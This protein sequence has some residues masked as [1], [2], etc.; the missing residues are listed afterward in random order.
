[1]HL[2]IFV[3]SP[4]DVGDERGLAL[5]VL[6]KLPYAGG[7]CGKVAIEVVA[8]DKP[9]AGTPMLA[10]MTPQA[11]IAQG[12]PKP[13]ACDIVVVIFWSRMGT[14]LPAEYKKADGTPYVSGTEW[15]YLDALNAAQRGGMPQILVY[16]RTED[17]K[18]GMSDPQRGEK[19]SQWEKVQRFFASF[20]NPDGSI[21]GGVN[22]YETPDDFRE[23]LKDHLEKIIHGLVDTRVT[24]ATKTVT[25]QHQASTPLALW[26]GSPFPG[27]RTFTPDDAPIFFGREREA[28]ELVRRFADHDMRFVVVAGASGSGKSS[29]AA[30]GLLPRLRANAIE[31]SKDWLLP[32]SQPGGSERKVWTG[33]RFTPGEF[34]D[35]PFQALAAKLAPLMPGTELAPRRVAEDL[36]TSSNHLQQLIDRALT[37]KPSWAEA[38]L[39]ID[40]F[41]ELFTVMADQY[42]KPFVDM[43]VAAVQAPRLRIVATL[44]AD[45]YHRCIEAQPQLADILRQRGASF[46]LAPPG[47]FALSEMITGPAGRAGLDFDDGLADQILK[48]AGTSSG[49]L[50]LLA[51]AL[52]ELYEARSADARLTRAAYEAFGGVQRAI[53][54]RAEATFQNLPAKA[55]ALL[56][57]VFRELVDV[58]EGG[59]ATRRRA[60]RQHFESSADAEQLIDAFTEAR[61]L[62]M[63]RSPGGQVFV[64][65][66]HEALLRE[67][68]RLKDWIAERTD[69]L[70]LWRQAQSAAAEWLRAGR[71]AI[72]LW[73]H[74]R[75]VSLHDTLQRLALARDNLPEPVKGFV[76]PEAERLL[77]EL[78]R[79]ATTHYR[80]AE[81][82]DRLDRIGDP[83]PGVG[84]RPDGVPDIL[85]CKIPG[86]TLTLQDVKGS[87]SVEPFFMAKYPV[88]YRQ[89]RAFLEDPKGYHSKTWWKGLT[90]ETQ[91]GEQYRPTGNCPAD[92]VS[93]HS[94]IA[95]CRWLS[96]H[97]R[98][99]VRLPTE[100]EWQQAA[101][102][103]RAYLEYPWG[104]EG[105]EGYANTSEAR[106]SRTTAVGMYPAGGSAQEILDLVGN[107][108]EWC[109]NKYDDPND[110]GLSGE[111]RRVLRGGSWFHDR[112]LARCAFRD[113]YVPEYRYDGI[114][115]RVV[116]GS[117]IF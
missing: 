95:Y 112:G 81:I 100:Q 107:V 111:V 42:R 45:F 84:L 24:A 85:W 72:H 25:A 108:W 76:R 65:V 74:E 32:W 66:A 9:G 10:T 92:N 14:P 13:S 70:R 38:L 37:G 83:R 53:G 48:D 99:E 8:W 109:A 50:A 86:G 59:A 115:F 67:W 36:A 43:L 62:V 98:Y 55:Q 78:D 82:G 49:A 20:R 63:D 75:L 117:P 7:L 4:G 31:G 47:A 2:R 90:R 71:D 69:D 116:C 114:G 52:H 80:R 35:N 29:L 41:E 87:F 15:E 5:D 40:Q 68:P 23:K 30:A 12:L 113:Y 96:A 39:F 73:P 79:P 19:F 104:P 103:A 51:F 16:R 6:D 102:G 101:T 88:T 56:G 61:L 106:L 27:L 58:D 21:H 110:V 18:V 89:Y 60:L 54:Q 44:R 33:L 17:P 34:S 22:D 97:L 91:P 77:E 94:A 1:L 64:E 46:P 57:E 93:W 28:G 26:N 11:A 3:A 105:A